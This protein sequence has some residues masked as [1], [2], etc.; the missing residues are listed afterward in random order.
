MV[1]CCHRDRP[2]CRGRSAGSET[3]YSDIRTVS[4]SDDFW[5]ARCLDLA[6]RGAGSVSPNPMVGSVIV[7]PDG[8][9]V[10]EGWHAE[11]GGDHAERAAV[12]DAERRGLADHLL[13]STLYVSLEPCNHHGRT[14][15]CTELIL[16]RRIPRVVV[17]T[18]D[19][20]PA[21]QGAGIA[22]LSEAGV[23]V[24]VG[25]LEDKCRRLNEAFFVRARSGRPLVTLKIAQTIDGFTA[26]ETGDSRWIS[27]EAS[28]ARVHQWRA[29]ADAVLVGSGTARADDPALTVRHVEGRQ[30]WRI[31]LDR[32]GT[33]PGS[34]RVFSDGHV[35]STVAVVG[36]GA[37][38]E[39]AD[40]LS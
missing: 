26:T 22:R 34:L 23:S 28:R 18:I 6:R 17:G 31:V 39:Y 38:P 25:V 9:V 32:E 10:G 11:W 36:P 20:S 7:A 2:Q 8:N 12:I 27:C 24:S 40:D 14:P 29:E 21:V 35:G 13:D 33:L 4:G 3:T 19:A 16:D 15:P 37:A 1:A 30:P 5:M